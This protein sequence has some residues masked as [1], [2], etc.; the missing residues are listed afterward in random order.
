MYLAVSRDNNF[1]NDLVLAEVSN[2]ESECFNEII[3]M[4]ILGRFY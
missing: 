2:D 1:S 3:L 4:N